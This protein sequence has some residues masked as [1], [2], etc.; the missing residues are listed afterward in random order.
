MD[1]HSILCQSLTNDDA[2]F[3]DNAHELRM[4]QKTGPSKKDWTHPANWGTGNV[5]CH[6]KGYERW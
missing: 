3:C 6:V 1:E 5:T 4:Q 2:V